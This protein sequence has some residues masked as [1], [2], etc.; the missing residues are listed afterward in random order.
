MTS[1]SGWEG[2]QRTRRKIQGSG[3]ILLI[4]DISLVMV[5]QVVNGKKSQNV[6]YKQN[7]N[8]DWVPCDHFLHEF[9][10]KN[11]VTAAQNKGKFQSLYLLQNI[12]K[13]LIC[14]HR[15]YFSKSLSYVPLQDVAVE[16][17]PQETPNSKSLF[18]PL[19]SIV[20]PL[21]SS[22]LPS[23][24]LKSHLLLVPFTFFDPLASS[25]FISL[26]LSVFLSTDLQF[27]PHNIQESDRQDLYQW[28]RYRVT[29]CKMGNTPILINLVPILQ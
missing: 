23:N 7:P 15:Q 26:A 25:S 9:M 14:K 1:H 11:H 6:L 4:N 29:Y 20:L 17:F 8:I 16:Y 13:S 21:L 24:F 18:S 3:K 27:L 2:R 5:A 12:K 19:P 28:G 22:L 10:F